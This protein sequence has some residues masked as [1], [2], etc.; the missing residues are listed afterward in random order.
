MAP[1][2]RDPLPMKFVDYIDILPGAKRVPPD[3]NERARLNDV[4]EKLKQFAK[5]TDLKFA[6]IKG[7]QK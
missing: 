2:K 4:S 6:I 5:E 1:R 7:D 3:D